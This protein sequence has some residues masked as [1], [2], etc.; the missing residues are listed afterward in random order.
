MAMCT[1]RTGPCTRRRVTIF[2][3][4][5]PPRIGQTTTLY[6]DCLG[7]S[8]R[9][10]ERTAERLKR[11]DPTPAARGSASR[12]AFTYG[13][14]SPTPP[15]ICAR[16]SRLRTSPAARISVGM[17]AS[18]SRSTTGRFQRSLSTSGARGLAV[19]VTKDQRTEQPSRDWRHAGV[20]RRFTT[21]SIGGS[22]DQSVRDRRG[23]GSPSSAVLLT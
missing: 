14:T 1:P 19:S 12:N 8:R 9:S 18:A 3:S 16:N 5:S 15:P 20:S 2:A 22:S 13:G 23:A 11:M 10:L 6:S 17:T 4:Q 21:R 7:A